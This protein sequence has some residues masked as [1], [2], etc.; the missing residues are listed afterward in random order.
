[1][2]RSQPFSP[3]V[4]GV[5]ASSALLALTLEV[6]LIKAGFYLIEEPSPWLFDLVAFC[7]YK[8][9]GLI[10]CILVG[11]LFGRTAFYLAIFILG[12]S[13]GLFFIRTIGAS[14]YKR[15][16]SL[17]NMASTQGDD[18]LGHATVAGNRST[19]RTYFLLFLALIQLLLTFFLLYGVISLIPSTPS[20]S[21][22]GFSPYPSIPAKVE[23]LNP[24][25]IAKYKD[26]QGGFIR[27][28][29]LNPGKQKL[30]SSPSGNTVDS[31]GK[32]DGTKTD[33]TII[34]AKDSHR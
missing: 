13:N 14:S 9:V 24:E 22:G 7:S 15:T 11:L 28:K 5:T 23:G 17:G 3:E 12:C 33:E 2:A 10:V 6:L 19:N 30:G 25:E 16:P 18:G 26:D 34:N 21:L 4:L 8:Y 29:I 32:T 20:L 1:V 31:L 27:D